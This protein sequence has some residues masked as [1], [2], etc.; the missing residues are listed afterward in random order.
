METKTFYP[1]W[2]DVVTYGEKRPQPQVLLESATYK[3]V[4]A[5]MQA[6]GKMPAHAEGPAV[7]HFLAGTGEM[8]VGEARYSV[9]A[10]STVVVPDQASR[11]IEAT[12][13][14]A[15]LAVRVG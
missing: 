4:I 14:L 7:F 12:S 5:G 11:A 8:L 9:Q 10:G 13:R 15:F 3:S 1:N 6:G 2:Q